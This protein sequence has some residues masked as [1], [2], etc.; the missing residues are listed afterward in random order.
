M[1]CLLI[2]KLRA[3]GVQVGGW[4]PDLASF[5]PANRYRSIITLQRHCLIA[6]QSERKTF[7]ILCH[8]LTT[9]HADMMGLAGTV[10]VP[11]PESAGTSPAPFGRPSPS[12]RS[13]AT[14]FR[15]FVEIERYR[16]P[17]PGDELVR[18]STIAAHRSS[19]EAFVG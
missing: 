19:M 15:G 11:V 9:H 10:V 3:S 4:R 8:G 18:I 1:R 12:S 13:V 6:P 14:V 2:L 17:R 5:F 16:G 7:A